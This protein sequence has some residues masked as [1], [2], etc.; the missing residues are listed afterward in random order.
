[1]IKLMLA[2]R[3][4]GSPQ[5]LPPLTWLRAFE[6]AARHLSF[7][8][9]ATEVNLTQSAISQHV[10]SLEAFLGRELFIRKT[11]ALELT[12][13]G[14]N[15]LPVVREAFNMLASGTRA[16]TGADRGRNLVLQCNMAFSVFWLAPRLHR[17]YAEYPWIVLNIVTPIWDPERHAAN[18]AMEIRFG[19][20]DDMS[21]AAERLAHERFFPVCAPD[22]HK[23]EVDLEKAILMD[24]AG[25]TG[26]WG[27][28]FKSQG[29]TFDRDGSVT[30]TS[31]FVIA[32]QA[33][34]HRAGV[35]MAHDTLVSDL[36]SNRVLLRPFDHAP[37][38]SE[39]YFLLSPQ[40]H[41]ATPAS[42]AFEEWLRS[43]MARFS[44]DAPG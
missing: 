7:T 10:R 5:D 37:E 25:L 8:R 24:C 35:A 20:P 28:W 14:S 39:A 13:D 31:T 34:I 42:R 12:E 18:A 16:F 9:A 27:T 44:Q 40:T 23:G 19:R 33:A 6:A 11:R 43:E 3:M 26:S 29:K 2:L 17:L 15:Y 22:Y 36:L 41:A 38:L 4:S 1:L 21:P 30:L 32:I